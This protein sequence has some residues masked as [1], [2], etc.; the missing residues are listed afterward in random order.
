[1][2][3]DRPCLTSL[4]HSE[5]TVH[6]SVLADESGQPPRPAPTRHQRWMHRPVEHERNVIIDAM[7]FSASPALQR[8]AAKM[9]ACCLCPLYV[10]KSNGRVCVAPGMCR[11]RMCPTC[12]KMRGRVVQSKL[13]QAVSTMDAPRFMTLTLKS[14]DD[15][16]SA[17]LDRLY[18]AFRDLR[19]RPQWKSRVVRGVAVCEVTRNA[20]DGRWH[21]HIH[22]VFDGEY[23]PQDLLAE[24]WRSV[25]G[26]SF[27]VDVRAVR[28]RSDAAKYLATYIAK[29]NGVV[30][31]PSDSIA[32][33]AL[34]MKGR[35]LLIPFGAM[36]LAK[37]DEGEHGETAEVAEVLCSAS[38]LHRALDSG[39]PYARLASELL[40]RLGGWGAV[41]VGLEHRRRLSGSVPL[42]DGDWLLLRTALRRVGGDDT[43]W[44]PLIEPLR[45]FN[46]ADCHG[47]RGRLADVLLWPDVF[48]PDTRMV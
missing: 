38:K 16:L 30:E 33:Y 34:A 24:L 8:R 19:R 18:L 21:A 47:T 35:R 9:D 20:E 36:K 1:M 17:V 39:C 46:G 42:D 43:A 4:D 15:G 31:W 23:F 13:L 11:D 10:A 45:R 12:Q 41:A 37:P 27:I 3:T 29:G 28:A 14:N 48:S 32:E 5:T 7:H 44:L 25:T 22:A 6:R 26:D 40:G 2:A